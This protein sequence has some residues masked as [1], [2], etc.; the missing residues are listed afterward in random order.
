[1]VLHPSMQPHIFQRS[2]KPDTPLKN[3]KNYIHHYVSEVFSHKKKDI[4]NKSISPNR[5]GVITATKDADLDKHAGRATANVV[6]KPR[7]LLRPLPRASFPAC[8]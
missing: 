1:M 2:D 6:E 5:H 3:K 4:Q 7:P 8:R